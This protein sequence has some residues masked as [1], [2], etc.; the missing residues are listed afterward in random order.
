MGSMEANWMEL[1]RNGLAVLA[2]LGIVIEFVPFIKFNPLSWLTG[3]LGDAMNKKVLEKMEILSKKMTDHE[4][5]Q[6]RWNILDFANSCRQGR[7]HTKDE[8]E[9]VIK[10]HTDYMRI[11]KENNMENG[12]VDAD[13]KYIEE[14]YHK[15]MKNNDFL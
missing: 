7:R 14:I 9:H 11:L 10:A 13:Y 5:D 12:Q 8:F 1:I 4:I 15:C 3:K 6:L 2:S